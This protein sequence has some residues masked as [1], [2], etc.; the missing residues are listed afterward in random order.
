MVK[1]GV[2][3]TYVDKNSFLK[4]KSI[5]VLAT[6]TID[7][8]KDSK[9]PALEIKFIDYA[10]N[11]TKIYEAELAKNEYLSIKNDRYFPASLGA[12][13]IMTV[14]FKVRGKNAAGYK[15]AKAD[16]KNIGLYFP[17][18]LWDRKRYWIDN[19]TSSHKLSVGLLIAPM[20]EDL[21]DKNTNNYFQNSNTSYTAFMLS[22]GISVTYTYKNLTFALIP[23]GFDYGLDDAGREWDYHGKYWFGFGIGVDTKLFG[24]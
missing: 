8:S 5:R 2:S 23:V 10:D 1:C 21:S 6:K 13:S 17:V 22:T 7:A 9:K 3:Q 4:A 15:T 24:F 19:S 14:P 11:T 18:A 20:A 12:I 16:I